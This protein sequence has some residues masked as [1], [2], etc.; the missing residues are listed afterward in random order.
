MALKFITGNKTK[1]KEASEVLAPIEIEMVDID[2]IEIQELDAQKIL[3]HKLKEAFKH[4]QSEFIVED[5]SLY[6]EC[7]GGKLPGPLIKWFN[8]TVGMPGLAKLVEKMENNKART[9]TIIGYAKSPDEIMFFK[10]GYQGTIIQPKGDYHFGYDPI[11][12]PDGASETLAEMKAKGNF[13]FSA[14]GM[15]MAKLKEHLA[16]G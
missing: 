6:M 10:G 2:L 12:V 5:S 9:E 7:L 16:N 4:E 11:F 14:R 1:F 8:E 13:N 3:E 15:A